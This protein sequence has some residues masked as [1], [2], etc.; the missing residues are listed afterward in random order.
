M[1]GRQA[2]LRLD[3]RT[4]NRILGL[5]SDSHGT[6][7]I[8]IRWIRTLYFQRLVTRLNDAYSRLEDASRMIA[9]NISTYLPS[10]GYADRSDG[11]TSRQ[12]LTI[13]ATA[14]MRHSRCPSG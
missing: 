11:F 3:C 9:F 5:H 4:A 14:F 12:N 2:D 7:V 6:Q 8:A 10:A 13:E 1:G